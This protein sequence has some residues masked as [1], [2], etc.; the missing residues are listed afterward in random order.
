LIQNLREGRHQTI[1]AYGT[2]LTAGGAWVG[3]L[4]DELEQCFPGQLR[5]I[6]AGKGAMNSDWGL[7]NVVE[8]VIVHRPDAV[9]LEFS[10]NDAYLP[11]NPDLTRCEA[12]L[13]AMINAI[14]ETNPEC[15][16]ILMVMNPMVGE[17]EKRR[18][19]LERFNDV[20]RRVAHEQRLPLI[21]HYPAWLNLRATDRTEF[22]RLVPDG[23]HPNAPGCRRVVA[24][25]ILRALGLV[26]TTS[27]PG[28][29][30]PEGNRDD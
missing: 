5:V 24:P 30:S 14:R 26:S 29:P 9:F 2:S 13:L 22:D 17:H 10:V 1:V 18:P 27:C 23:A 15:E 3:M 21:D 8:R 4:Q 28:K 7:A 11:Y 20:Y 25:A 19:S 16:T 6:N 12:N